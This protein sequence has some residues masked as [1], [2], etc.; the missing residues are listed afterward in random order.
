MSAETIC[1]LFCVGLQTAVSCRCGVAGRSG[2]DQSPEQYEAED[3]FFD[4]YN[5]FINSEARVA[6]AEAR[7]I[8]WAR[9]R[10]E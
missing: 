1:G 5:K 8:A 2:P 10:S 7:L 4:R 6:D 3:R 9:A